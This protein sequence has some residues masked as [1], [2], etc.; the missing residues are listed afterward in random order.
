MRVH[1]LI[2]WLASFEDQD[3]EVEVVRHSCGIGRVDV[4]DPKKH[5]NYMDLRGNQYVTPDQPCYES[6]TLLLGE[7]DS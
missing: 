5:A 6:R 3:A 7:I 4:F 2:Q 1:E